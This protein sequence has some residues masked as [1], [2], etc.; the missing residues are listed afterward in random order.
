MMVKSLHHDD[1]ICVITQWN[2]MSSQL[3]TMG[4]VIYDSHSIFLRLILLNQAPLDKSLMKN[5]PPFLT[6]TPFFSIG[7]SDDEGLYYFVA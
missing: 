7:L 2:T 1:R 5:V 3:C 4:L 6:E